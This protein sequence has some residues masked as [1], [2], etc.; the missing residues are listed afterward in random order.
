MAAR[1]WLIPI[2]T[3]FLLAGCGISMPELGSLGGDGSRGIFAAQPDSSAAA[4]RAENMEI[5]TEVPEV[6]ARETG[7][8]RGIARANCASDDGLETGYENALEDLRI[9]VANDGADYLRVRGS[10]DIESRGFCDE[11]Y[12]RIDGVGFRTDVAN[13]RSTDGNT[14]SGADSLTARLEELEAL[15]ERDLITEEEYDRLRERVMNEPY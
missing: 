1:A 4:T 7:Q 10:G 6:G 15:R 11:N 8:R 13:A 14:A 2:T 3:T 5:S 9:K 12:Y